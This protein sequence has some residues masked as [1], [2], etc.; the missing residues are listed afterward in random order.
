MHQGADPGQIL[1]QPPQLSGS[2]SRNVHAPLQNVAPP[3]Q[4]YSQL[5]LMHAPYS[6]G[7]ASSHT[8]PQLPQL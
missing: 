3:M 4:S 7:P 8:L 6:L 1:P 2:E 5:P